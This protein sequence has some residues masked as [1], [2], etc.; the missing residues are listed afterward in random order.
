[1][2]GTNHNAQSVHQPLNSNAGKRLVAVSSEIELIAA[3]GP[4]PSDLY[5]QEEFNNY[6]KYAEPARAA[7]RK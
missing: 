3:R 2:S 5:H 4:S 6:S 1:M 7:N